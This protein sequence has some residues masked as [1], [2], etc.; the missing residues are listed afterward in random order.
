VSIF[1]ALLPWSLFGT[2]RLL[3]NFQVFY[4]ASKIDPLKGKFYH[5][6]GSSCEVTPPLS[7]FLSLVNVLIPCFLYP[8]GSLA[9]VLISIY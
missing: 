2:S 8:L 9:R 6:E 4:K 7:P 3:V 5:L 1:Q